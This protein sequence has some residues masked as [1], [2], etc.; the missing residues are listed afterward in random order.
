[1]RKLLMRPLM[2]ML[3]GWAARKVMARVQARRMA[4]NS[5]RF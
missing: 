5:R 2:L 4:T 1:M 3:A